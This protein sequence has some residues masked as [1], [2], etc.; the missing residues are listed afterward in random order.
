M[1][2][3]APQPSGYWTPNAVPRMG[4]VPGRAPT[5]MFAWLGMIISVSG[6]I[7]NFG[8][9]GLLGAVFSVVGLREARKL[10]AAG[11]ADS[12]RTV[13]FVG[14]VTGIVHIIVTIGLIVV[15]V[16]LWAWFAQWIDTV[17]SEL[18]NSNLSGPA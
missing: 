17:T 6:F 14:L 1:T 9:N 16:L 5:N 8:V 15:A 7:V 18:Q 10:E 13:A 4:T 12:G 11:F 3:P 2:V